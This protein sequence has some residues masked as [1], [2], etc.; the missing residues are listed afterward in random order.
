MVYEAVTV[1]PALHLC[2]SS[3]VC[4][5]VCGF[6][7]RTGTRRAG[8]MLICPAVGATLLAPMVWLT[9]AV[10]LQTL[11]WSFQKCSLLRTQLPK[12]CFCLGLTLLVFN[13]LSTASNWVTFQR[14][15]IKF[16]SA[17]SFP[18]VAVLKTAGTGKRNICLP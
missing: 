2:T 14:A 9:Q 16:K 12:P 1:A 17:V 8:F 6:E 13:F 5:S 15:E 4:V 3:G 11:V 7:A 18:T 10:L